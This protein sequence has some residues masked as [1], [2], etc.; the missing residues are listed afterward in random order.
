MKKAS[1]FTLIELLIVVAIISILAAIAVP[2]FLEAQTRAKV[3]RTK[4]DMRSVATAMESYR[5]DTN[6]YP[7]PFGKVV[8]NSRD[9]WAVL[10]TPIAYITAAR[11]QDPFTRPSG[12]VGQRTLTYEACNAQNLMLEAPPTAPSISPDGQS[13]VWWWIASRGPDKR[14]GFQNPSNDPEA[15]IRVK[16]TNSDSDNASWLT[17]V[18][19]PTNG[20]V[21][22]GNIYRAGGQVGGFA[23]RTM[24]AQ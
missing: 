18:Y 9:S 21:S 13:T 11:M 1:A 7:P 12:S 22:L 15:A 16:F 23:G 4:A 19:D 2:N 17:V 14:Y 3:S 24:Q 8:D 6:H 20:T 10:S 5:V